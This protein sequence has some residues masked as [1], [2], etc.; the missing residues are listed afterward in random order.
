MS[1]VDKYQICI[2]KDKC[3]G[4]MNCIRNCP[5]LF[6]IEMFV[7]DEKHN[8]KINPAR[9][10]NCGQC[11]NVCPQKAISYSDD[12]ALF[13]EEQNKEK[14]ITLICDISI[15]QFFKNY[16]NI[17]GYF[18][19]NGI[20]IIAKDSI[21]IKLSELNDIHNKKVD[22]II[23]QDKNSIL[24]YIKKYSS[25]LTTNIIKA[26]NTVYL[27]SMYI[28]NAGNESGIIVYLS[29]NL[30]P[31]NIIK[32]DDVFFDYFITFKKL[33]KYLDKHNINLAE[34]P[35]AD[36][37]KVDA[38]DS[39][40]LSNTFNENIFFNKSIINSLIDVKIP[41]ERNLQFLY[42]KLDKHTENQKNINCNC[43]GYKTCKNLVTAVY[44][45]ITN[46]NSCILYLKQQKRIEKQNLENTNLQMQQI[47][48][49][50]ILLLKQAIETAEESEKTKI[51][52]KAILDNLIDMVIVTDPNFLIKSVNMNFEKALGYSEQEIIGSS[53]SLLFPNNKI[54]FT[55]N[56]LH[57]TE[58]QQPDFIDSKIEISV[59]KKDGSI[60]PCELGMNKFEL[61]KKDSLVFILRDISQHLE[62]EA[63]KNQ[64]V[65]TVSHELR[66]PLTAIKGSLGLLT[67]G[68]LGSFPDKAK[69]ILTVAN[70]N[71]TRLINLINDILDLEKIKRGEMSF[72]YEDIEIK[73]IIK[74]TIELNKPYADQFNVKIT[75]ISKI[76]KL[77]I[78]VD[79]NRLLQVLSNLI[80]NAIKFSKQNEEIKI[81]TEK[82]K[83]NVKISIIDN[84]IGIPEEAKEK[85]FK[86]FSQVDSTDSRA[87]GGTGL[88]LY[89]CKMIIEKMNGKIDFESIS[90]EGS[91]FFF[92]IPLINR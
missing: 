34:Y 56:I 38:I 77:F 18:K 76:N 7:N 24:Y 89:I 11:V 63:M 60:I 74:Q 26:L 28:K 86:A 54:L 33:E 15:T 3:I 17:F 64:F 35:E 72:N 88:G 1:T 36:F 85:I 41:N 52:I 71:C 69:T 73:S 20:D 62:L 84:G 12:T 92:T 31:G 5:I 43:C 46:E 27:N 59:M 16:K 25:G 81:I 57:N 23:S 2:D 44:N 40:N 66:T 75:E 8:I 4:C 48:D 58:F 90:G 78:N 29:D 39:I 47:N 30:P 10:T 55:D 49:K 79:K 45:N 21:S 61:D 19:A 53:L 82:V 51:R 50:T 68:A 6:S 91:S 67:S 80:S 32:N 87:K 9:C 14:N 70:N 37:D 65:S 13:F 83:E 42:N 22:D